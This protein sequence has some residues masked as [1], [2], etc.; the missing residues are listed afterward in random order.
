MCN[1]HILIIFSLVFRLKYDNRSVQLYQ[2]VMC[3]AVKS[4]NF[5]YNIC[6]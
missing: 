3:L 6:S 5:Q 2:I 1:R 4:M